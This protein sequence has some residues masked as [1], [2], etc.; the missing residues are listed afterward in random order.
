MVT[1]TWLG[2]VCQRYFDGFVDNFGRLTSISPKFRHWPNSRDSESSPQCELHPDAASTV[3]LKDRSNLSRN[4]QSQ[5]WVSI[6][7]HSLSR[8]ARIFGEGMTGKSSDTG[9]GL[10]SAGVETAGMTHGGK[11]RRQPEVGIMVR[12]SELWITCGGWCCDSRRLWMS[13]RMR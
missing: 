10:K 1:E 2:S 4:F 6:S 11:L 13:R 9:Q 8:L 12:N 5:S 7:T 3:L